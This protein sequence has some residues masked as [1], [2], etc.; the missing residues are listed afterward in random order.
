MSYNPIVRGFNAISKLIGRGFAFSKGYSVKFCKVYTEP[1]QNMNLSTAASLCQ[2]VSTS[3]SLNMK[4]ST[5]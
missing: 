3:L 4:V 5:E 2:K 1:A